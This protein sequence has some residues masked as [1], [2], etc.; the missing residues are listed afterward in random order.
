MPQRTTRKILICFALAL[1]F[2]TIARAQSPTSSET[3][4]IPVDRANDEWQVAQSIS[5]SSRK[6]LVVTLHQPERRASCHIRSFTVDKLV[7]SRAFGG[8]HTYL[9]Q[10][11]IALI[12][13]GDDDVRLR[14]VLGLNAVLGAAIWGT[15]VLAPI[16][17]ACAVVTGVIALG[18]FG[19]TGAVLIGDG[20]PDQIFYLAPGQKL[21]DKL[22]SVELYKPRPPVVTGAP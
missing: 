8:T 5:S 13:P 17:P 19:A 18:L 22:S 16:C 14:F 10:Q 15:V 20:Q 21:T 3:V 7:C 12:L 1:A 11:V 6:I 2:V 9:R 4:T